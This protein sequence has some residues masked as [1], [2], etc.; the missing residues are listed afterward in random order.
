MTFVGIDPAGL[1]DLGAM[2]GLRSE[3]I[4]RAALRAVGSL[5][6]LE[7][8]RAADRFGFRLTSTVRALRSASEDFRW[9]IDAL[10]ADAATPGWSSLSAPAYLSRAVLATAVP[11]GSGPPTGP[12][13]VTPATVGRLLEKTPEEV[14]DYFASE[15]TETIGLLAAA[16]PVAI[17]AMDGAPPWARYAAN[18]LLIA[19]RI[20]A[21]RQQATS[22]RESLSAGDLAWFMERIVA[23][24]L[25]QIG[26]EI[27]ELGLWLGEDRQIL[28]F[29]PVG[30]GRVV[31]VFGDLQGAGNIGVV[32]PGITNDRA[33]FSDGDGGFR[34]NARNVHERA[35]ELGVGD[36][37][38]IAWLGYDTPDGLDAV[39]RTAATAGHRDLVDFVSGMDALPGQRHITVV[40]HS[41][42]SL[43]TGQ[44]AAAG[45]A[46][47]E[48]VFVGS[49]GTGLTHAGDARLTP[50]GVVWAGLAD[51]DPIGAGVNIS[52]YLTPTQRFEQAVRRLFGLIGGEDTT[53][54]L[55]HGVNPAHDDFGALEIHTDGSVGHSEY[56]KPG[57]MTLDNL[58]Y[59][60]AGMDARVS[61]E[62]PNV[63][64]MAPGPFGD[65]TPPLTV[66]A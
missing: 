35:G 48:V 66:A 11:V 40:G 20:A 29:D 61:V 62:I 2:L 15:A 54:D 26:A 17:G 27:A 53:R 30:D 28:L 9:R 45:L 60:I 39:L 64:D 52:E 7:M 12:V 5:R 19:R 33:N 23:V 3:T 21:L 16:Y 56:F 32:V 46:A 4:E 41:Y 49:P 38:T 44:A 37:A 42:G 18:D 13:A 14:A 43:V 47:N 50:G 65:P 58:V 6:G 22:A 51:G 8:E 24:Q 10:L 34:A 59:I 57:T 55:H 25:G 63:V 36:L 31:E 1:A